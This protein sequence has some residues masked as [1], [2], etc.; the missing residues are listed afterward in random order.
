LADDVATLVKHLGFAEAMKRISW[1]PEV[2]RIRPEATTPQGDGAGAPPPADLL[3][4][5]HK[6]A[7]ILLNLSEEQKLLRC[8]HTNLQQLPQYV[9]PFFGCD[10]E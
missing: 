10:P 7:E 4:L 2:R 3:L 5:R 9:L 8:L 6:P 1:Y